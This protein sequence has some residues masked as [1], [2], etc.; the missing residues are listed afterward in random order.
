MR[1]LLITLISTFLSH[2]SFAQKSSF[3]EPGVS[4][5]KRIERLINISDTSNADL[6]VVI[7]EKGSQF[8][9]T[10]IVNNAL[11]YDSLPIYSDTKGKY[12]KLDDTAVSQL[13][14]FTFDSTNKRQ[15]LNIED[16]IIEEDW[17]ID[18]Q[19]YQMIRHYIWF[20]L[21]HSKDKK[22]ENLIPLFTIKAQ[23]FL[24]LCSKYQV[25]YGND[26]ISLSSYFENRY[27][28]SRIIGTRTVEIKYEGSDWERL[29][30]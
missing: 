24:K 5:K 26:K 30:D 10:D 22:H 14:H 6:L 9:I 3:S 28:K 19:T 23:D 7:D 18:D 2:F 29:E 25:Y 27:F 13:L 16:I 17:N 21:C 12:K 8:T 1:V 20:Q 11:I 15:I 4:F